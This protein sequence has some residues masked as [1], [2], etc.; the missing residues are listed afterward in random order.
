MVAQGNRYFNNGRRDAG[1]PGSNRDRGHVDYFWDHMRRYEIVRPLRFCNGSPVSDERRP[2][3]A[4]E[5]GESGT[6]LRVAD[7]RSGRSHSGQGIARF[8]SS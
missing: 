8:A 2:R 5:P 3:D 7:P 6:W 1:L 4:L